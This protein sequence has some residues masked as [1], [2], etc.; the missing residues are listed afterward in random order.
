MTRSFTFLVT[1]AAIALAWLCLPLTPQ[2]AAGALG[3]AAAAAKAKP[4]ITSKAYGTTK[5]GTPVTLYT[6]TNSHGVEATITN[7]GGIIVS[8]KTPDR[9]GVLGDVVLGFDSLDPYLG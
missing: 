8:L 2:G 3:Q 4:G 9:K 5:S 7:Y 1:P 6:L